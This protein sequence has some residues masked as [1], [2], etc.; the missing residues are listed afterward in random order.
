MVDLADHDADDVRAVPAP[1]RTRAGSIG[2]RARSL[3]DAMQDFYARTL[4]WA[5]ATAAGAADALRHDRPQRLAS[6]YV[7]PK[8]FFP[9][10]D[11]GRMI[12]SL[13]ADQSISFQ[14]MSQKLRR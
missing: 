2:R 3:F 6:I 11:T 12:G 7:V 8:G 14:L 13:Q 4:G 9:Q 1:A 5:L 10:Q